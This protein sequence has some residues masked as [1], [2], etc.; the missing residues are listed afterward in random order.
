MLGQ[1]VPSAGSSNFYREGP[2]S[3][4]RRWTAVYDGHS[5]SV[6]KRNEGVSGS[7]NQPCTLARQRD[8]TVLSRADTRTREQQA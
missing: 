2:I 5:A 3:T 1:T 6:R 8:T 4:H 7:R